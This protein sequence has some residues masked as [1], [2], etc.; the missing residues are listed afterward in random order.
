MPHKV[1]THSLR[2]LADADRLGMFTLR[3]DTFFTRLGWDVE[4]TD[5]GQEIDQYDRDDRSKYIL[6]KSPLG[7]VDACWRLRP[8]LGTNMLR[9]VFPCLLH[10][11]PAPEAAD[12]WELSRFAIATDRLPG[13]EDASD[14]QIGF[15]Q[16]SIS[17]MQ[18]S[19]RFARENGIA[20]YVTVTTAAIERMLKRQGVN[21]H[22]L[23]P[24][25]RIGQVMTVACFIEIDDVTAKALGM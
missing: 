20:R 1:V 17:L 11:L 10:G 12:V 8:T 22:R 9:D 19:V 7:A 14:H 24:P 4:T 13:S 16:L 3:Y 18:E 25:M 6:A 21:I 2:E 23:G 5:D 15:G